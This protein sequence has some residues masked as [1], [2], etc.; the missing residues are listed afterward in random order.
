[1]KTLQKY[2]VHGRRENTLQGACQ[3]GV[4]TIWCRRLAS[5]GAVAANPAIVTIKPTATRWCM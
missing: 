4:A 2:G 3:N 5:A 1:L